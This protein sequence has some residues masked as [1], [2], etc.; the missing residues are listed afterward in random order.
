VGGLT[1]TVTT[2]PPADPTPLLEFPPHEDNIAA[3]TATS[4]N[5]TAV[6]FL[7]ADG[8]RANPPI[9]IPTAD[10]HMKNGDREGRLCALG[11]INALFGP[12]VLMVNDTVCVPLAPV[13]ISGFEQ[14][15]PVGCKGCQ[16]PHVKLTALG[17][18]VAPT[19][20]TVRL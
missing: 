14:P 19:G 11:R 4:A 12:L 17:N 7:L 1:F 5:A 2:P 20:V 6:A 10:I 3:E 9:T 16:F 15:A 18:A 8:F 13:V